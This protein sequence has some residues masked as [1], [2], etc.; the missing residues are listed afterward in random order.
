MTHHAAL[1]GV[2]VAVLSSP[3]RL[4][5]GQTAPDLS[6]PSDPSAVGYLSLTKRHPDG[7]EGRDEFTQ[8]YSREGALERLSQIRGFLQSFRQLTAAV[9]P[10]LDEATLR[11][12]GNTGGDMQ[13][14]GF[15]N[16]PSIVEGTLLKQDYELAQARYELAQLRRARGDISTEELVRAEARYQEATKVFQAFWDTR[17]PTD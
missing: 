17:L 2:L 14:I 6:V 4:S 9:R 13:T 5:S 15:H 12:I 16:I 3:A 8:L 7:L 1:V 10:S 11:A